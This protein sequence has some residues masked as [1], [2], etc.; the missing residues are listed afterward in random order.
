MTEPD[1]KLCRREVVRPSGEV[2][3]H[4]ATITK[5]NALNWCEGCRASLPFW[6]AD[7]APKATEVAK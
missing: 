3:P 7:D 1:Y 6:P 2:G 5:K 4:N